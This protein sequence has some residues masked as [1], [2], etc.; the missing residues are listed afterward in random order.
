MGHHQKQNHHTE[1][2]D[3]CCNE[4][5]PTLLYP[6]VLSELYFQT[7]PYI[8]IGSALYEHVLEWYIPGRRI[9]NIWTI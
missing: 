6:L 1:G 9:H 3:L 5:C 2:E 7:R 8:Y 4:K